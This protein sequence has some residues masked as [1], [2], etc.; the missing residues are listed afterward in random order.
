MGDFN[1]K[2][3]NIDLNEEDFELNEEDFDDLNFSYI[4]PQTK[5]TI[6]NS[7]RIERQYNF[8]I[9][10]SHD[11]NLLRR[12]QQLNPPTR[13][14]I[15]RQH[16]IK[17]LSD[18]DNTKDI[19][20]FKYVARTEHVF[21]PQINI[22]FQCI[23]NF[24][25]K[26]KA[27]V[28]NKNYTFTKDDDLFYD[29]LLKLRI[30]VLKIKDKYI[31]GING[32]DGILFNVNDT[33]LI[34][35]N[36]IYL[37]NNSKNFTFNYPEFIY[38]C[39]KQ[40]KVYDPYYELLKNTFINI[41]NR[42]KIN[43]KKYEKQKLNENLILSNN[44]LYYFSSCVLKLKEITT[45]HLTKGGKRKSIKRKSIKRKSIKILYN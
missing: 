8:P 28:I 26:L 45:L 21:N 17:M 13:R 35:Q 12:L 32:I 15:T 20:R 11:V 19:E 16:K 40:K 5:N 24:F 30:F 44:N 41:L 7:K 34:T 23:N 42:D 37:I 9:V 31:N 1:K 38:D 18:F 22:L 2:G 25:E 36:L 33:T 27:N 29:F 14:I 4:P 6:R 43:L 39:M 3:F 10:P